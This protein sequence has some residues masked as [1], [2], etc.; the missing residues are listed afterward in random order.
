MKKVGSSA[1]VVDERR[2]GEAGFD[3]DEVREVRVL[4]RCH[5][6]YWPNGYVFGTRRRK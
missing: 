5:L 2:E 3:V 6:W 1:G 4:K